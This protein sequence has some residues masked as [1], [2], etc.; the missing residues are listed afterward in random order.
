[1]TVSTASVTT[2]TG[3]ADFLKLSY[4]GMLQTVQIRRDGYPFRPLIADFLETYSVLLLRAA[5]GSE[6]DL[7]KEIL[8]D[9]GI[10]DF[11]IG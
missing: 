4:T 11:S 6:T 3:F 8:R 1:M 7:C 2:D 9:S 5:Q 10:N